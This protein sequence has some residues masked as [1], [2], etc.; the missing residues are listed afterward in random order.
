MLVRQTG[1]VLRKLTEKLYDDADDMEERKRILAVV[2]EIRHAKDFKGMKLPV[3]NKS[4]GMS[5]SEWASASVSERTHNNKYSVGAVVPAAEL[6]ADDLDKS[7]A[8]KPPV[9]RPMEVEV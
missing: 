6:R 7:V 5:S 2:E 4:T 1:W 3:E 8:D 9:V